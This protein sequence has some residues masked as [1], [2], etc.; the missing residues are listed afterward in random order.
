MPSQNHLRQRVVPV[1]N[2]PA[3]SIDAPIATGRFFWSAAA[4]RRFGPRRLDAGTPTQENLLRR[5][6]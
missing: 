3:S 2:Q 4:R 1:G 5:S 6:V